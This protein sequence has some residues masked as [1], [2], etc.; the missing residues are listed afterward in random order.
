MSASRKPNSDNTGAAEDLLP[1]AGLKPGFLSTAGPCW[2]LDKSPSFA[3]QALRSGQGDFSAFAT[4]T[5]LTPY[6]PGAL[7]CSLSEG[8]QHNRT[9]G[10]QVPVTLEVLT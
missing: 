5:P 4:C 7:L 9:V 1:P 2:H 6:L 10:G 8:D 3:H